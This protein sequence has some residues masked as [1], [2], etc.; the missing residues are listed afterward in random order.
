MPL[1][2][3]EAPH[4]TAPGNHDDDGTN[5]DIYKTFLGDDYYS[6]DFANTHFA[7]ANST[8]AGSSSGTMAD[9]VKP[10]LILI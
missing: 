6:F 8:K 7:M 10:G 5:L 4:F 2:F 3:L 9:A 1:I